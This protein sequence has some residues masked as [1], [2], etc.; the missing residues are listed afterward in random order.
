MAY[1][2]FVNP[3]DAVKAYQTL[4]KKSF[5]GR[6]L[7]L[8]PA[9]DRRPKADDATDKK[10]TVKDEKQAQRKALAGKEFNWSMLYMNVRL[11]CSSGKLV[12][13]LT[14]SFRAMP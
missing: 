2:T 9:V 11:L 8:L 3:E 6:I 10:R 4:D 7:H 5:Q 1:V 12:H 13:V 14:S